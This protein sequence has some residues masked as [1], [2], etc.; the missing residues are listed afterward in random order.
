MKLPP[1]KALPVFEAV[2]RLNSFS[3]A[4]TE[5][6]VS[7]SAV[8]HQI[9]QLEAYLG[10]ELFHRQG[11]HLSLTAEGRHYQDAVSSAL[12]QL[13]RASEQVQG[14]VDTRVRIAMYSSIAVRWLIPR[15]PTL[16]RQHPQLDL[17]LE[18]MNESPL[19]SD[20][21]ADCFI[22]LQGEHR[23][24]TTDLLY[25]ERM[26]AITSRPFWQAMC[27]D[28]QQAGLIDSNE[29]EQID[30]AWLLRYPLLSTYSI[31]DIH[32][33]DWRRWFAQAGISLP[34]STRV[35]HF[36]HMLMALEAARHHQGLALTNDY[37]HT[38]DDDPE[39]VR[40][41]C[42]SLITGDRFYF[43]FKTARRDE[44][45]IRLLRQ[46]IRQQAVASGLLDASAIPAA[47]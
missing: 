31:Y 28:W 13:E 44:N 35:Q 3:R 8:S 46:W 38:V 6:N 47:Q 19:L 4:A 14:R 16:Q 18:M 20:R 10:E 32:T 42:H 1:L 29:P 25:C 21:V 22:T 7:Q 34:D 26:F 33:E 9:Q 12:F 30:P 15:L 11:R 39:L 23:G 45:G 5:L 27:A 41:P 17:A 43:A 36:S 24:F 37:M 2:A 40:L